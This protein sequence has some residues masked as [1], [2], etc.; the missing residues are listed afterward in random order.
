[1]GPEGHVWPKCGHLVRLLRPEYIQYFSLS[2]QTYFSS[3]AYS[4]FAHYSVQNEDDAKVSRATQY[5]LK[6]HVPM[7][8]SS[9]DQ[10]WRDM[11]GKRS[12]KTKKTKKLKKIK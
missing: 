6:E 7:F 1:M 10:K 12:R 5:L 9:L 8:A 2:F 11:V 3:D 4:K